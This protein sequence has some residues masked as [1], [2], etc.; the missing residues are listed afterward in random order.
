MDS[1]IFEDFYV[2]MNGSCSVSLT[3]HEAVQLS[4]GRKLLHARPSVIHR[5]YSVCSVCRVCGA[6]CVVQCV[7]VGVIV[8]CCE[9]VFVYVC[10]MV[11]GV[12]LCVVCVVVCAVYQESAVSIQTMKAV[13]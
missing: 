11:W 8:G 1:C 10:G 12:C 5:G 7:C 3:F 6:V 9:C 13:R 2:E 4:A